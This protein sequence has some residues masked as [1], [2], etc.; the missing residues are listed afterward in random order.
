[1]DDETDF[2]SEG[3]E[4]SNDSLSDDASATTHGEPEEAYVDDSGVRNWGERQD[5][6]TRAIF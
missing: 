6:I 1:M 5:R 4:F 3:R 2:S